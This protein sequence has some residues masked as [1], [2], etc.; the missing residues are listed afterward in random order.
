MR[1]PSSW[2]V[3]AMLREAVGPAVSAAL[4]RVDDAYSNAL[5]RAARN[6]EDVQDRLAAART[7]SNDLP[8]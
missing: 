7:R 6:I 4:G 8:R 1:R 2:P 5:Q 3:L